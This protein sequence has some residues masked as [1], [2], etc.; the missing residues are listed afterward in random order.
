MDENGEFN[1]DELVIVTLMGLNYHRA[2][3]EIRKIGGTYAELP[4]KV[5]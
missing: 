3:S 5:I 2:K 4:E 1:L